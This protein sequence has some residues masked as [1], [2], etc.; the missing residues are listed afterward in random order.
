MKALVTGS[1][2]FLGAAVVERLLAHG[3]AAPRCLVRP[4]SDRSRLDAIAAAHPDQPIEI[5]T[6]KL[7]SPRDCEPL[8]DGVDVL[9]HVAAGTA[10]GAADMFLSSVV[11]SKNLLEV[12]PTSTKVVLVSSFGVYGVADLPKGAVIDESTPV[13][14][15]PHKRD[16]YSHSKHRQEQLFFDHAERR[17]IA[18]TTLRPGVI[19][20]PGGGGAMSSRVGLR[21]PGVFL[22]L[23]GDNIL[24]LSYVDNCAEA[25]VV[26]GKSDQAWGQ[27]YNVHDDDLVSARDFLAAYEEQVQPLRKLPVPYPLLLLG[28]HLVERYH[29]YSRGQLPAIFTP[30]KTKTMWKSH[31]FSNAK[32]KSLGWKQLVSTEEG[33]RRALAYHRSK[34]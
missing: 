18:L 21:M 30:Y 26:A 4:G 11:A 22:Y 20:G 27:I 8:I 33:M 23:G 24:P 25:L 15:Q 10:G 14:P 6:G 5:V 13:D 29:D 1:N 32:L 7:S 16:I 34:L 3:F 28:S 12:M 2:G 17:G 9:F 19:Y 31:R